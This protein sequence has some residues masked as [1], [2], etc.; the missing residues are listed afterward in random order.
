M[1]L[2]CAIL[3]GRVSICWQAKS[4]PTDLQF[5]FSQL[6]Y[7]PLRI[8]CTLHDLYR[9]NLRFED[10]LSSNSSNLFGLPEDQSVRALGSLRITFFGISTLD[11]I[12]TYFKTS[13]GLL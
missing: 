8:H 5:G 3:E 9:W 10:S 6:K 13:S 2:H 4:Y 7:F 11:W 1:G 12:S